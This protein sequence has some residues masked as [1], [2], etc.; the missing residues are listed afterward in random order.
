M[1]ALPAVSAILLY[2]FADPPPEVCEV[3]A[4][5]GELAVADSLAVWIRLAADRQ[6]EGA[7]VK[8]PDG[9]GNDARGRRVFKKSSS[10]KLGHACLPDPL[11]RPRRAGH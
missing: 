11:G 1:P 8:S 7:G 10:R 6:A 2:S 9:C 3:L 5:S 4:K